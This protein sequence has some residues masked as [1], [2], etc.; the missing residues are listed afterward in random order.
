MT[1]KYS[2]R[3][4]VDVVT[5]TNRTCDF[6]GDAIRSVT[7]QRGVAWR[8]II[9]DNA[10]GAPHELRAAVTAVAAESGDGSR[11]RITLTRNAPAGRA[12]GVSEGRNHG[13]ALGSGEY[14]AFLDD[15]DVWHPEFLERLVSALEQAPGAVG[16]YCGGEFIDAAG[17]A[18]DAWPAEQAT[19]DD[20]LS[21]RR[22]IPRIMAL[23]VRR[24][25]GEAIGWFDPRYDMGEDNEFIYRL[26]GR[27]EL[28]A[29]PEAL[30][31]YRR[32]PGNT[33]GGTAARKAMREADEL[34]LT[35]LIAA[36]RAAG[37]L[38]RAAMLVENRAQLR[39]RNAAREMHALLHATRTRRG[40]GDALRG[41]AWA[42]R[43]APG[44]FFGFGLSRVLPRGDRA[45]RAGLGDT[46]VALVAFAGTA[47]TYLA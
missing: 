9:V 39:R 5:S 27:G 19:A 43:H 15:D 32:H 22:A 11:G 26:L 12:P 14:V 3:P 47:L 16:A 24:S 4:T 41:A 30:V 31:G 20:M 46:S 25:A 44:A 40:L 23:V 36:S 6:F 21:G 17:V 37:D 34:Y 29:V 13:I 2:S 8:H 18:F 7:S 42:V 45:R 33:T 10:S 28:V 1:E 35:R 38:P